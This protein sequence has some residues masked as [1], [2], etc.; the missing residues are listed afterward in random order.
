[1]KPLLSFVLATVVLF[2]PVSL[3]DQKFSSEQ[4]LIAKSKKIHD[5]VI[6]LDTHNDINTANFTE[7]V[8]SHAGPADTGQ[9]P[10]NGAWRARC[11]VDDRL[12]RPGR[13]DRR[14]YKRAYANAIDKLTRSIALLK[15]SRPTRS[16]S[17]S[18]LTTFD[19]S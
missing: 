15:R 9:H 3:L 7:T 16:N 8:N 13:V 10:Q 4:A 6:T 19:G 1:M 5:E 17:R 11:F 18:P 12:Y 14:G 2:S